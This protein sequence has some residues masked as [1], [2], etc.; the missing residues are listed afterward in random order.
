MPP[1]ESSFTTSTGNRV[2]SLKLS[3]M[4]HAVV[5]T[6]IRGR[7]GCAHRQGTRT[8]RIESWRTMQPLHNF[9][10]ASTTLQGR[11]SLFGFGFPRRIEAFLDR[12]PDAFGVAEQPE[13]AVLDGSASGECFPLH[14][15]SGISKLLLTT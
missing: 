15:L 9:F 8:Q 13:Y 11:S 12:A 5:R 2:T 6:Q 4:A 7:R 10:E 14:G 1:K 3:G